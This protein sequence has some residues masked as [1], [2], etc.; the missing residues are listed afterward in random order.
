MYTKIRITNKA[1]S[2]VT[3]YCFNTTLSIMVT[4]MSTTGE[5]NPVFVGSR[6]NPGFTT[7]LSLGFTSRE[8]W[9]L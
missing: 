6:G 4:N 7:L 3:T 1:K 8:R 5:K 9:I 2:V